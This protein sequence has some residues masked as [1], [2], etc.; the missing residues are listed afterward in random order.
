MEQMMSTAVSSSF[1]DHLGDIP[2]HMSKFF[3][4]ID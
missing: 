4:V 1:L 3:L 2:N